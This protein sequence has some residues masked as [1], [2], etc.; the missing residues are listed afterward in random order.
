M[1]ASIVWSVLPKRTSTREGGSGARE[2]LEAA[3]GSLPRT[4]GWEDVAALRGM[5]AVSRS[6][7][8]CYLELVEAIEQ[9]GEIHVAVEY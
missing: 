4:L 3:F 8:S 9:H 6:E 5:H 7:T 2:A 1:S